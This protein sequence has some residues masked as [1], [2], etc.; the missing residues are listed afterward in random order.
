MKSSYS[1]GYE[2][3]LH[4]FALYYYGLQATGAINLKGIRNLMLKL[5]VTIKTY[6]FAKQTSTDFIIK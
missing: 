4:K 3:G 2:S 6:L 1:N 5:F